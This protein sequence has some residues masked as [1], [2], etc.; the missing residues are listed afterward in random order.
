[1]IE[2]VRL[3]AAA[4]NQLST[5]KR[6]YGIEHYNTICRYALCLSLATPGHLIQE[7]LVFSGG[8][9]IDWKTLT[10]GNEELYFNLVQAWVG[11]NSPASGEEDIRGILTL[12]LHRGLSFLSGRSEG[13]ELMFA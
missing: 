8:L 5:L 11:L 10:G 1:M 2:R 12:H 3:T 6:R 9:E 13:L 7:D 4:K